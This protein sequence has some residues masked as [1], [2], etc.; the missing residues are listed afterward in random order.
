[1]D[2]A[3]KNYERQ[4]AVSEES[5]RPRARTGA[6]LGDDLVPE[7]VERDRRLVALIDLSG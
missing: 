5:V 4:R 3:K 1:V 7:T 6:V 2:R